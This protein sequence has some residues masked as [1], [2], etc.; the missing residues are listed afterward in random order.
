MRDIL[1]KILPIAVCLLIFY[2][3]GLHIYK[4]WEKISQYHWKFEPLL[5]ALATLTWISVMLIN[6]NVW[7]YTLHSLNSKLDTWNGMNA[8]ILSNFSKYIP[9][10]VWTLATR[11]YLTSKDG[12]SKTKS[13]YSFYLEVILSCLSGILLFGLFLISTGIKLKGTYRVLSIIALCS[14]PVILVVVHP[15]IGRIG[16]NLLSKILK[17][18]LP[19]I[20]YSYKRTLLITAMY[21]GLWLL[22]GFAILLLMLSFGIGK[23]SDYFTVSA[24][25]AI[26]WIGGLVSVITPDGLGVREG[27]FALFLALAVPSYLASAFTIFV[28]IWITICEILCFGVFKVLQLIRKKCKR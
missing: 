12:I 6:S 5:L 23:W 7:V 21:F 28:R 8:W 19:K 14:A 26:S 24:G 25:F 1:K 9:G 22:R 20:D 18:D 11:V 10:R 17:K 2:F 15:N 13:S 4:N 16:I 3:L 27:L